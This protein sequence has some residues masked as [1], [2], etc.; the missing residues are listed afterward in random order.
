MITC[1]NRPLSL[2]VSCSR[3]LEASPIELCCIC[4]KYR[5]GTTETPL[6]T[7][8]PIPT[9]EEDKCHTLPF[10]I[11]VSFEL[12]LSNCPNGTLV[13]ASCTVSLV[14]PP[15]FIS[16]SV[17]MPCV[18]PDL[19]FV[20]S[21]IW[22]ANPT[23]I[24]DP[25]PPPPPP[26][27]QRCGIAYLVFV[28]SMTIPPQRCDIVRLAGGYLLLLF[29]SSPPPRCGIVRLA[30]AYCVRLLADTVPKMRYRS[31]CPC[32]L[33]SSACRYCPQNAVSFALPVF[34][35]KKNVLGIPPQLCTQVNQK[36]PH[37]Q[38]LCIRNAPI[39][40][41]YAFL[42]PIPGRARRSGPRCAHGAGAGPIGRSAHAAP[43]AA[44]RFAASRSARRAAS[45]AYCT[46][47]RS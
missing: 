25:S 15:G 36:R 17:S 28:R 35:S 40:N 1:G 10:N 42:F 34:T 8:H 20:P 31:P 12:N 45:G 43:G 5:T 14:C 27:P 6:N 2:G 18:Q 13:G 19:N 33:C 7:K 9:A 11:S 41:F 46:G 29:S 32:L 47:P 44:R 3:G 22:P 23:C 38:P 39:P 16:T 21:Y 4:N 37:T 26:P 30:R 24:P